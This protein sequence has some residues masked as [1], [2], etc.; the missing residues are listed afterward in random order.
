MT[1]VLH[2]GHEEGKFELKSSY[3]VHW[4]F[5]TTGKYLN[6]LFLLLKIK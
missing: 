3:Y 5:I 2:C 4:H 6:P 1:Q